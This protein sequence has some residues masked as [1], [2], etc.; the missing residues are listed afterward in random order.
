[1]CV[2]LVCMGLIGGPIIRVLIRTWRGSNVPVTHW[3]LRTRP[4]CKSKLFGKICLT[5]FYIFFDP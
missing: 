1:M 5:L 3:I 4:W 2:F